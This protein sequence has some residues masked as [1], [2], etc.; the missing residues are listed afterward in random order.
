MAAACWCS[1]TRPGAPAATAARSAL[2]A[3]PARIN[4][5]SAIDR[6]PP[7]SSPP[8]LA[9]SHGCVHL[10]P[11]GRSRLRDRGHLRGPPIEGVG[12]PAS[13]GTWASFHGSSAA[14]TDFLA[15]S[16]RFD[17]PEPSRR[18]RCVR[19]DDDQAN[20]LTCDDVVALHLA[21]EALLDG[22]QLG[23]LALEQ[24]RTPRDLIGFEVSLRRWRAPRASHPGR[25]GGSEPRG[26]ATRLLRS[27]RSGAAAS[28]APH[29]S[30]HPRAAA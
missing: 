29:R 8:E 4:A 23:E 24:Q 5:T 18:T 30:Y 15:W 2:R 1:G 20:A 25:A 27:A 26:S 17:V 7:A 13:D 19:R 11:A 16:I 3:E 14:R 21:R 9:A 12:W 28:R 6:C 10:D 22:G